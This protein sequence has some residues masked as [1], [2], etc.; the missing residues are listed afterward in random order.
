MNRWLIRRTASKEILGPYT[1]MEVA[2][3]IKAGIFSTEDYICEE[4]FATWTTIEKRRD[5]TKLLETDLKEAQR[6]S[7]EALDS[8]KLDEFVFEEPASTPTVEAA[9]QA[10]SKRWL[11]LLALAGVLVALVGIVQALLAPKGPPTPVVEPAP[12]PEIKSDLLQTRRPIKPDAQTLDP[13]QK[14]TPE[15]GGVSRFSTFDPNQAFERGEGALEQGEEGSVDQPRR[16][17]TRK[18]PEGQKAVPPGTS[19]PP[20]SLAPKREKPLEPEGDP[21]DPY[22]EED[23]GDESFEITGEPIAPELPASESPPE[24]R[25]SEEGLPDT[26]D[27]ESL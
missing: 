27:E 18:V 20:P 26:L 9:D 3:K 6:K 12:G 24:D 2:E 5:I 15:P 25:S 4:G 16:R 1:S 11:R 10:R 22:L 19:V 8:K 21:F 17:V 7:K 23:R 13:N 14:K